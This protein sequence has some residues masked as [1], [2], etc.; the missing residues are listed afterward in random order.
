MAIP[1]EI[2]AQS[3]YLQKVFSQ[4]TDKP[5]TYIP[6]AVELPAYQEKSRVELGVAAEPFAFLSVFDCNGWYQR[7]NPLA[8]VRA[9]QAAFA[10]SNRDVQL[11][12]KMM[13]SRPEAP[14]HQELMRLAGQ[15]DRIVIIDTFLSRSDMLALLNCADVFVSLHR[16]EG[17]GRVVAECMLLGKPVISTNYSGSVDFAHEGTAYVVDGPMIN[18][19]KGDYADYE[20]QSWMDPD[21]GMAATAMRRCV[22]DRQD[23]AAMALRGQRYMQDHHSVEAVAAQY[24][25]RLETLGVI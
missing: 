1:D 7:K 5:V 24:L 16:S 14:V 20:G 15:D 18:L 17:F 11:I 8:A 23:T 19:K 4:A 3:R 25:R 12:V 2:W 6:S 21:M 10:P 9:F 22:D 13:N